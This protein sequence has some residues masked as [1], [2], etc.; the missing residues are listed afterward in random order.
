MTSSDV[1]SPGSSLSEEGT[2]LEK[3]SG[4]LWYR[5]STA[6]GPHKVQSRRLIL[7]AV[8]GANAQID[9]PGV[10]RSERVRRARPVVA[11]LICRASNVNERISRRPLSRSTRIGHG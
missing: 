3:A 1:A 11:G 6:N 10:R 9:V 4:N 7:V 2:I 8:H 5:L